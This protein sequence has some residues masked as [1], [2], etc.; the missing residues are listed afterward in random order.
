MD[1]CPFPGAG[2]QFDDV[3]F[4]MIGGCRD[5]GDQARVA[6]L[7]RLVSQLRLDECTEFRIN[8]P[9]SELKA[10]LGQAT[11][12]LHTMW[13]EHFGKLIGH[14]LKRVIQWAREIMQVSASWK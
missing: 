8:V 11:A 4:A 3:R 14:H 7:R 6:E 5:D 1:C 2:A 9:L 13:N 12:G 10:A